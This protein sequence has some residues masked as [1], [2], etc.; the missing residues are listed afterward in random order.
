VAI[1]VVPPYWVWGSP[2][3]MSDNNLL[4]GWQSGLACLDRGVFWDG[5]MWRWSENSGQLLLPTGQFDPKLFSVTTVS[6][7]L[8]L[9]FS[10]VV[11][12]VI[13]SYRLWL[14]LASPHLCCPSLYKL[15]AELSFSDQAVWEI[16]LSSFGQK[17]YPGDVQ[18][19]AHKM[20]CI[21]WCTPGLK[22][23]SSPEWI[24]GFQTKLLIDEDKNDFQSEEQIMTP[25][26]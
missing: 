10:D 21:M 22:T 25:T 20:I 8:L 18:S 2:L 26:E 4:L 15:Q 7:S 12:R 9:G 11:K 19:D 6:F 16:S 3:N 5:S 17:L 24:V 1:G 13:I 14:G 23:P